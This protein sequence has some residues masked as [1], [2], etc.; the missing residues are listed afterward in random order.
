MPQPSRTCIWGPAIA[1]YQQAK[2]CG[3]QMYESHELRMWLSGP[4][5]D[6]G[7]WSLTMGQDFVF[8]G[9][10]TWNFNCQSRMLAWSL[11]WHIFDSWIAVSHFQ[12]DLEQDCMSCSVNYFKLIFTKTQEQLFQGALP[13]KMEVTDWSPGFLYRENLLS[14]VPKKETSATQVFISLCSL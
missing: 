7:R 4:E 14:L 2:G 6:G 9:L 11:C 12:H 5:D 13:I 1:E 8:P 10:L 3:S